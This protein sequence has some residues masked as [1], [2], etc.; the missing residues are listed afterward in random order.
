MAS[1]PRKAARSLLNSMAG[2]SSIRR[3]SSRAVAADRSRRGHV[4]QRSGG[5]D[6]NHEEQRWI[7]ETLVEYF[8]ILREW[9]LDLR[10]EESEEPRE[11]R[12]P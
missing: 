6:F 7:R 5:V 3:Q 2:S 8:A 12:R 9:D 11:S 4:P 1:P 10:R